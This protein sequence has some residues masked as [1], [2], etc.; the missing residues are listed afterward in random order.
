MKVRNLRFASRL[1][2]SPLIARQAQALTP[3]HKCLNNQLKVPAWLPNRGRAIKDKLPK[4]RYLFNMATRMDQPTPPKVQ[5]WM[6]SLISKDC[7]RVFIWTTIWQTVA[8]QK[9]ICSR[10]HLS[11][12]WIF[13]RGSITMKR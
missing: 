5:I 12:L 2:V 7:R 13:Y 8:N 6:A 11:S 3:L 1:R 4:T 9:D 10:W